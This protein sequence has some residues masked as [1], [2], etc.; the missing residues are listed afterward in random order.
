MTTSSGY[1]FP[2]PGVPTIQSPSS[3]S[4]YASASSSGNNPDGKKSYSSWN[5]DWQGYL[6]Y[7]A[8]HGDTASLDKLMN[9]MMSEESANRQREWDSHAYQRL[10]DD[11]KSAGINPYAFAT[12]GA[13]PISSSSNSSYGGSYSSSYEINK[14]KNEQNWLKIALSSLVPIIGGIIAAFL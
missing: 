3:G 2:V 6:T 12:M 1:T 9:Y 13:N 11:M 5:G 8:D 7:M 10:F 4:P 14:E